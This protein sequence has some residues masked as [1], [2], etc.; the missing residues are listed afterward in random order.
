MAD[1]VITCSVWSVN[2]KNRYVSNAWRRHSSHTLVICFHPGK[3]I[4]PR[5]LRI[6]LILIDLLIF[7]GLSTELHH[8]LLSSCEL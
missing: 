7:I 4:I 8:F 3:N 6:Q 5:K 1:H 2:R